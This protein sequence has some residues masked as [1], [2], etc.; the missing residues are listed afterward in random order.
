MGQIADGSALAGIFHRIG[1]IA[2]PA[3]GGVD[4]G[5]GSAAG[6]G[7]IALRLQRYAEAP[8]NAFSVHVGVPAVPDI[9]AVGAVVGGEYKAGAAVLKAEVQ[10]D[11]VIDM[12]GFAH[13]HIVFAE[14]KSQ[15][16]QRLRVGEDIAV[17]Q[18]LDIKLRFHKAA[19]FLG[20]GYVG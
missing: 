6:Q 20:I 12:G 2:Q 13:I 15:G 16:L 5:D 11:V 3:I 4:G 18:L 7:L 10:G 19:H 1:A 14:T 8:E 17:A 9:A